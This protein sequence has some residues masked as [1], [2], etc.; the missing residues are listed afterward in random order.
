MPGAG[1]PWLTCMTRSAN[2]NF[3]FSIQKD[4]LQM[5]RKA[6]FKLMN[7]Q[8]SLLNESASRAF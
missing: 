3:V 5:D 8:I 7:V 2:H 6:F 1:W 4:V